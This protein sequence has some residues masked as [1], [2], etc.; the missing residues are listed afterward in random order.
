M[1][2]Q[3]DKP[4]RWRPRFSVRTLAIVVTLLCCYAAWWGPTKTRGVID[5]EMDAEESLLIAAKA[6]SV[7]PLVLIVEG[8]Q[9][10]LWGRTRVMDS[11]RRRRYYFWFFGYVAKLPYERNVEVIPIIPLDSPRGVSKHFIK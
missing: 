5:V 10:K 3:H 4:K 7:A 11:P 8:Y 2:T 1:T 6:T 9:L